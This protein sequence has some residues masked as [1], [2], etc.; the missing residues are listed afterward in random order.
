MATI[1]IIDPVSRIEGHMKVEVEIDGGAVTD[2]KVSGT[3]FRGFE[4]ILQ[5]RAPDDAPLLT[6][7][8]CG[9]CPISHGTAS[10]LALEDVNNWK[11]NT[12]GRALR[13]LVLG[14]NYIQSHILHFYVLSAVDFVPGPATSPWDAYWNVDM[15]PGLGGVMGHFTQALEA[16]RKAHEMAAIFGG[17]IPHAAAFIA[18]GMTSEVTA[19]KISRFQ[20]YLAELTAFIQNV[21]IPDVQAVGTVYSDYFAKG[22]GPENLLS[23]GVFD[24]SG[25]GRHL[26]SGYIEKGVPGVNTINT[27]NINEHVTYSWYQ[28]TDPKHP[29]EG[30]TTPQH[31]K[32]NA[33]SWLKSPRYNNKAVEVGPLARMKVSGNY[34]GGISVMDR[35]VARAKEALLVAQAMQGWLGEISAGSGYD[36]SFSQGKG[37]GEGLTEAARGALGHWANIG[38][39]GKISN[40]QVI[41]PTCWNAS[42][43]DDSGVKGPM[44]QALMGTPVIDASKPVE[45]IRIIHSF[46]PCIACAVHVMKPGGEAVTVAHA[47]GRQIY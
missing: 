1:T 17:K 4:M 2:V 6:Q 7:R 25:G 31:P 11:P 33:Y 26:R 46:D 35:H 44:E 8:I 24:L 19:E 45:V 29:S 34:N 37:M 42:P 15:R 5:G 28:N 47:G 27:N 10:V 3:L 36:S 13:N 21:Y 32:T 30:V 40:Y 23:Y 18:G 22:I 39:D 12:N 38:T 41:T 9:V 16:R 14:S 20:A 43:K